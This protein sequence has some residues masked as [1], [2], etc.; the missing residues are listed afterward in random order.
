MTIVL[1][2]NPV[3]GNCY[4]VRLILSLLEIDFERRELSAV[5]HS[6]RAEALGGLSPSLNVPTVVLEEETRHA[7]GLASQ[8]HDPFGGGAGLRLQCQC[9][10]FQ[11]LPTR[12]RY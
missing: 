12:I 10:E 7:L 9:P 6:D 4:K 2:D 8:P 3:S 1:Y 11:G 5:D